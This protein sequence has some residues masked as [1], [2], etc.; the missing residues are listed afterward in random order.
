MHNGVGWDDCD[1]AF[2]ESEIIYED[3]RRGGGVARYM[4]VRVTDRR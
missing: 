2:A 4:H 3:V 1:F